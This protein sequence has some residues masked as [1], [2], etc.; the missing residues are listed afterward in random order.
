M[1]CRMAGGK[2]YTQFLS[3][4]PPRPTPALFLLFRFG[5]CFPWRL[6]FSLFQKLC[7][8]IVSRLETLADGHTVS[9]APDLF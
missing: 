5:S 6:R 1:A 3:P 4:P 8:N 7:L 2:K 9:N